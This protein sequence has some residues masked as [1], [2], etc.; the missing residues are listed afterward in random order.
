MSGI[1]L[2]DMHLNV[3]YTQSTPFAQDTIP[4]KYLA[5]PEYQT[6]THSDSSNLKYQHQC[7]QKRIN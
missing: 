6:K 2:E 7:L 1:L 5:L 4:T 3:V